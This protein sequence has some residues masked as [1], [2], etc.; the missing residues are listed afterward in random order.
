[1]GHGPQSFQYPSRAA[2]D[3]VQAARTTWR[4]RW[5]PGLRT[6]RVAQ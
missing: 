4:C 2:A 3:S 5:R 6:R 1:M